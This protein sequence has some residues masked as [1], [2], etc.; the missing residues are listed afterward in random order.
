MDGHQGVHCFI[1]FICISALPRRARKGK[2]DEGGEAGREAY[3]DD[4]IARHRIVRSDDWCRRYE[5]AE[6]QR[7]EYGRAAYVSLDHCSSFSRRWSRT[8]VGTDDI[9][10]SLLSTLYPSFQ[11]PPI[12][13]TAAVA[14]DIDI[15]TNEKPS[16]TH[17]R[18]H[19]G[20]HESQAA[21]VYH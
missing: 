13:T 2:E 9:P 16:H 5:S 18:S 8:R 12:T 6:I 14:A 7:D 11:L 1:K 20:A 4:N 17:H 19:Y 3:S 15:E 21:V 10:S